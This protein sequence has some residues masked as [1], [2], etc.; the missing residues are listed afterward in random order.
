M[1]KVNKVNGHSMCQITRDI[2]AIVSLAIYS[3]I[4]IQIQVHMFAP[5][6][7]NNE[8]EPPQ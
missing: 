1:C 7:H 6:T 3:E 8:N 4:C 2:Y 5:K